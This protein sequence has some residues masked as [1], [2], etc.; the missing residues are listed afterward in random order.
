MHD[1][2][3]PSDPVLTRRWFLALTGAGTLGLFLRG[4]GGAQLVHAAP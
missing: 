3:H 4:P 1:R 2:I